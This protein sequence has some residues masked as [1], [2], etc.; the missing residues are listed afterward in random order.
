LKDKILLL[1]FCLVISIK[2][3]HALILEADPFFFNPKISYANQLLANNEGKAKQKLKK[4][5]DKYIP[6]EYHEH[7]II[8]CVDLTPSQ[9]IFK[10][11]LYVCQWEYYP[12]E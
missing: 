1:I 3:A 7:A 4:N 5:R 6:K 12:G 2:P 9:V 11:A 8:Y 10:N